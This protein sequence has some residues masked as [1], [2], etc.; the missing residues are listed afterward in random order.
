MEA[1]KAWDEAE[2][3][4][5]NVGVAEIEDALS[6]EVLAVC[7]SYYAQT[8]GEALNRAGVEVSSVL[9]KPENIFYP[10]AILTL[11]PP[12]T[13]GEMASAIAVSSEEARL[14]DPPPLNQQEQAKELEASKE[15]SSDA[16]KTSDKATKILH[17]GAASQGFERLSLSYHARRG[18][19]QGKGRS[20]SP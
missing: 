15:I 3:H 20:G 4:G 19:S 8:W 1:E 13:Q 6:V 2:Q 18:S 17:G 16:S 11:N 14:Q 10:L 9:R 7:R 5:Y 12:S